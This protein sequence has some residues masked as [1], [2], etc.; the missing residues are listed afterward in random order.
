MRDVRRARLATLGGLVAAGLALAACGGGSSS[1]A[2]ANTTAPTASTPTTAAGGAGGAGFGAALT[3]FRTCMSGHGITITVPTGRRNPNGAPPSTTPGETRPA[4]GA[5]GGGLG[6]GGLGSGSGF[7]NRYETAPAGVDAG[8]YATA[9]ADC[10][11]KLP[12]GGGNGALQNNSAFKAYVSCLLDHGV[13]LPTTSTTVAGG[14]TPTTATGATSTPAT[15]FNR[16]DPKVQ[17]AMKTCRPLLPTRGTGAATT[18][19][20]VPSA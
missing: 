5:G 4:R 19:T 7:A 8:T 12:T 3:A 18:T 11:A 17:A 13:K 10:K 2:G 16:N 9:Y 14:T 1:S 6:G 20:T 15:T